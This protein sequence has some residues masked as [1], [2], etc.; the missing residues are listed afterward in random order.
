MLLGVCRV[1]VIYDLIIKH[2]INVMIDAMQNV[3]S[4]TAFKLLWTMLDMKAESLI[5]TIH[6]IKYKL[7][8]IYFELY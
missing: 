6:T 5:S 4:A 1:K 7:R 2:P 8:S 3:L